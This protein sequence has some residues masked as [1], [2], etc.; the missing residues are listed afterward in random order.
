M[1]CIRISRN[2]LGYEKQGAVPGVGALWGSNARH[3][4][5][6]GGRSFSPLHRQVHHR[7]CVIR[8]FWSS[9]PYDGNGKSSMVSNQQQQGVVEMK[10][11]VV[12]LKS[13][14][15]KTEGVS[16]VMTVTYQPHVFFVM[17]LCLTFS[18]VASLITVMILYV[19]PVLKAVEAA[20]ISAERAAIDMEKASEEMEKTALLFQHDVPLT[21]MEVQKASEEWELVG[22]QLNVVV[23]SVTRPLNVERPV[24]MAA[25]SISSVRNVAEKSTAR[26]SRRIVHETTTV[27]NNLWSSIN[28]V[29]QQLGL[30][31]VSNEAVE[32]A[33]R[34]VYI[35]RQQQ[36][37]RSWIDRWRWRTAMRESGRSVEKSSDDLPVS[38]RSLDD[39]QV[40]QTAETR[41]QE[42]LSRAAT[43]VQ[44]ALQDDMYSSYK[45]DNTAVDEDPVAEVFNAL[46]RAQAAAE[47]A[48]V[49]SSA[50]ER[51][52]QKA[53]ESG[54]LSSS[55]EDDYQ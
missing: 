4:S 22:K 46:A 45:I 47:E 17:A 18:S 5:V 12:P 34:L 44:D 28:Q 51:A 20:A 49:S 41:E 8:A 54:M 7:G 15:M 3:E 37:A 31:G 33:K 6:C 10:Q 40:P 36:E 39:G 21:M 13:N 29:A 50:L 30:R 27:A 14:N 24:E 43:L 35:G 55:D 32:E 2:T 38:L 25:E 48:A 53:E 42:L 1:T 19:R 52:L 9:H 26:F 11:T 23:G 16:H